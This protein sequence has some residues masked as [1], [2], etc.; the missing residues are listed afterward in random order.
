LKQTLLITMISV[1]I[2]VSG[3]VGVFAV[4][5]ISSNNLV[6]EDEPIIIDGFVVDSV[7]DQTDLMGDSLIFRGYVTVVKYDAD[8]NEV[9]REIVH[10]RFVDTGEDFA[11]DQIFQDGTT[12]V[13]ADQM[14][15]ICIGDQVTVTIAETETA[16]DF[17]VDNLITE[18]NCIE[19]STVTTATSVATIGPITFTCGG[20]NCADNDTITAIAICQG[21]TTTPFNDCEDAQAAASGILFSVIDISDVTLAASETVDITY[22]FDI[23]SASQ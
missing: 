10:N 8:R 2:I 6:V 16:N 20:T 7:L 11:L 9:W 3:I 22:T 17:D 1:A 4:S 12:D 15:S 19:D 14:S 5:S 13:D 21:S 23:V 18:N